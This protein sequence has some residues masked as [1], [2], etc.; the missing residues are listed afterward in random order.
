MGDEC[1]LNSAA[2]GQEFVFD[3]REQ[4]APAQWLRAL[5]EAKP[6][7]MYAEP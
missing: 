1:L 2:R 6:P 3:A 7:L 4:K 5:L